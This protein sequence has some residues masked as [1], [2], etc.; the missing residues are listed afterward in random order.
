MTASRYSPAVMVEL[1][2]T[3]LLQAQTDTW[4]GAW[5]QY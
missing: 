4:E 2:S 3:L 5:E 1:V